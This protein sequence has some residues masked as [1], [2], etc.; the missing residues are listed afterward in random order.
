[1]SLISVKA[2][3]GRYILANQSFARWLG[4]E[5]EDICGKSDSDLFD[6]N[7]AARMIWQG[8]A[9][10]KGAD[11]AETEEVLQGYQTATESSFMSTRFAVKDSADN[12]YGVGQVMTDISRQKAVEET[13][14]SQR[15]ELHLLLDS[16]HAAIWY[17]DQWGVIKEANLVAQTLTN[18]TTIHGK[19][20]IELAYFWD[21]PAE[22]Q[23]EIMQVVRTGEAQLK[24]V[25]SAHINDQLCWFSVDKIP[26]KNKSGNISGVLLMM[27]D[28]TDA[29][30]KERTLQESDA[31][32]KAFIANSSEAIWCYDM[33]PP[34]DITADLETQ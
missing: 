11:F 5:A 15:Q 29:L 2:T 23:R 17:L 25:E 26:T 24:S 7:T 10:L 18:Q 4:K 16:M 1:H 22:R 6:A 13:L 32:Y 27:T 12:I 19:S 28:I 9:I 14:E 31:R 8:Q 3:D 33:T 34:V 20:F 21:D 30:R